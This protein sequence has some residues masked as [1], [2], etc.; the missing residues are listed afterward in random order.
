MTGASHA[1]VVAA[2]RRVRLPGQHWAVP[3]G[4]LRVA[5]EVVA[6]AGRAFEAVTV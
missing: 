2:L 6:P 3:L 1:A 5:G 4:G